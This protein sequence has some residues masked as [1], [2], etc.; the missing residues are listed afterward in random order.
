MTRNQTKRI[1]A[2][3]D[4][5]AGIAQRKE[6]QEA[7]AMDYQ[8]KNRKK[9]RKKSLDQKRHGTTP[10]QQRKEQGPMEKGPMQEEEQ[11]QIHDNADDDDDDDA[12]INKLASDLD[13]SYQEV[14]DAVF[15]KGVDDLDDDLTSL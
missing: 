5:R 10:M 13:D 14:W 3:K 11:G 1:A 6:G 12:F 8:N 4:D 9:N 7:T 15:K 2:F